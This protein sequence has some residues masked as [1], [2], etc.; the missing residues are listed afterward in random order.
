MLL[1]IE[2]VGRSP[3]W[4]YR[5][6]ERTFA[7]LVRDIEKGLRSIDEDFVVTMFFATVCMG[8]FL[9]VCWIGLYTLFAS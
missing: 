4:I 2:Y 9:Y 6:A 1:G 8:L 5:G 3:K 7:C